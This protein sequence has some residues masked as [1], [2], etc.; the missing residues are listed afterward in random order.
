M[1]RR[2]DCIVTPGGGKPHH[3]IVETSHALLKDLAIEMVLED[4]LVC[5]L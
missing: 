5:H 2:E 4:K 3:S 1:P